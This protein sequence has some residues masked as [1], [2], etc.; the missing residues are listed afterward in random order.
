MAVE[1]VSTDIAK[2]FVFYN[3]A[4]QSVN[5]FKDFPDFLITGIK[6]YVASR[7]SRSFGRKIGISFRKES[8]LSPF[9]GHKLSSILIFGLQPY[10]EIAFKTFLSKELNTLIPVVYTQCLS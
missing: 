6:V 8:F 1:V 9:K 3:I 7:D 5:S 4:K 10:V 2:L